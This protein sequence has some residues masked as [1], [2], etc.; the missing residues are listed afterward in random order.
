MTIE[1]GTISRERACS[2]WVQP[3]RLKVHRVAAIKPNSWLLQSSN[4][5]NLLAGNNVDV[6]P[7][8]FFEGAWAGPFNE[9]KFSECAEVFGSGAVRTSDGWLLVSPSHTLEA[10]YAFHDGSGNWT[11][12]NSLAFLK[13]FLKFAFQDSMTALVN[14]F[15]GIGLGIDN[16]PARIRTSHGTLY[17]LVHYN[18]LLSCDNLIIRV[19]PPAPGFNNFASYRSY[20]RET[21]CK[22]AVNAAAPERAVNYELLTTIS[23]GYDS[24]TCAVLA[25]EAGCKDA[26]TFTR[27]QYGD[28]DDGA[29]IAEKLG[30]KVSRFDRPNVPSENRRFIAELFSTGAQGG[31]I[32]YEPLRGKLLQKL[33]V[34]GFHGDKIWDRNGVATPLIGRT[35]ISGASL[36]EF[37]LSECFIHLPVPFIGARNHSEIKKLAN[38]DEMRP[39]S[40]GGPY[41][42]PIARRI[43]EEAGISRDMFGQ[44]KKAIS[45]LAFLDRELLG[46]DIREEIGATY[47]TLSPAKKLAYVFY[48]A[49]YSTEK[50]AAWFLLRSAEKLGVRTQRLSEIVW[51]IVFRRPLTLWQ[52]S[53]PFNILALDWSLSVVGEQYELPYDGT[54]LDRS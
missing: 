42:R 13:S 46:K 16:S 8:S 2:P 54:R 26:I 12:S 39:H 11:V 14:G 48:S 27:S 44:I 3:A 17:V 20:L 24:P 49:K 18:A 15:V 35:D 25:R 21:I 50:F 23:T 47:K 38:S 7:E 51:W 29:P 1:L 41:D 45:I 53:N 9:F 32:V 43:V 22:T 40:I 36:T 19:K 28:S 52:H 33:F 31:E 37:R 30:L 10:V 5:S 6:R 4:P 34:T